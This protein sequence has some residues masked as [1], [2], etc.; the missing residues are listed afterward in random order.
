MSEIVEIALKILFR[1]VAQIV[2][3]FVA[4]VA[5]SLF[6]IF[7]RRTGDF[8]IELVTLDYFRD[9]SNVPLDWKPLNP[10]PDWA[11]ALLG[12]SF[13]CAFAAAAWLSWPWLASL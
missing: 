10:V 9:H 12:L 4:Y 13:W 7:F 3:R 1:I 2:L 8:L 11:A 5:L 6:F